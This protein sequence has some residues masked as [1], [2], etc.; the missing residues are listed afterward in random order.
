MNL[1]EEKLSDKEI[2]Q[3]KHWL[4]LNVDIITW[5]GQFKEDFEEFWDIVFSSN[6]TISEIFSRLD[7]LLNKV[8]VGP[9]SSWLKWLEENFI[10][11]VFINKKCT[12]SDLAASFN[13]SPSDLAVV[14]RGF[15]R[16][17]Y[18]EKRDAFNEVF[19]LGNVL[20]ENFYLTYDD[21]QLNQNLSS[22]IENRVD[23]ASDMMTE[24]EITLYSEWK[25]LISWLK[26]QMKEERSF[27]SK[28]KQKTS[29]IHT[30]SFIQEVLVL[31]ILGG[32]VVYSL[33]FVNTWYDNYLSEKISIFDLSFD[34]L[35]TSKTFKDETL[36]KEEIIGSVQSPE[37]IEE[38]AQE[39]T[40][41]ILFKGEERFETE[42]DVVFTSS[43][44]LP[45]DFSTLD[46]ERSEYEEEQKG[47]YRDSQFG[48]NKAYRILLNSTDTRIVREKVNSLLSKYDVTKFDN[49]HPGTV[50][51]GG[52]YYNL[53]ISRKQL[54]GFIDEVSSL[55]ESSV[56][57]S[58]IR[59]AGLPGKSKVFIWIKGI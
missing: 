57:E 46:F 44:A 24:L 55:E 2:Q 56:Y 29:Y 9:I 39:I 10:C 13:K 26:E 37:L 31:L 7:L 51:P 19:Q 21:I 40:S 50:I 4:G 59:S 52:V 41:D 38:E 28:L 17:A 15:F 18:P 27:Y 16:K 49:V 1:N 12:I 30:V 3:F 8:K 54:K 22:T 23:V 43:D 32:S 48:K 35:D 14:L 34:W 58:R 42:S 6:L 47:G 45:K 33:Q 36:N 11:Y 53:F 5:E 20:S 25:E